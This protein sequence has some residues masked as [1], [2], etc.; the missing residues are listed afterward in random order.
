[1]KTH[2][3]R[4]TVAPG[5]PLAATS[6]SVEVL[7]EAPLTA[8]ADHAQV[9]AGDALFVWGGDGA[10]EEG[11]MGGSIE[12]N[13]VGDGALYHPQSGRWSVVAKAPLGPRK[14]AAAVWTGTEVIVAGGQTAGGQT[15]DAPLSDAASYDPET[16]TWASLPP[17]PNCPTVAARADQLVFTAGGCIAKGPRYSLFDPLT[18]TWEP[19][20]SPPSDLG[21]DEAPA[22]LLRVD[23]HIV[24]AGAT[25][26]A[27]S[28]DL[29]AR[30]WEKLTSVEASAS[31]PFPTSYAADAA[32][33]FA[34]SGE[35]DESGDTATIQALA[36]DGSW[37]HIASTPHVPSE[38][39]LYPVVADGSLL[40]GDSAGLCAMDTSAWANQSTE[41]TVHCVNQDDLDASVVRSGTSWAVARG[42]QD[43]GVLA[44]AWGGR[45]APAAGGYFQPT[46][47]GFA[48]RVNSDRETSA[49]S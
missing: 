9:M 34:F 46:A 33:V 12:G 28:F 14:M 5:R 40:Y 31:S 43:D 45:T 11:H 2:S 20:S 32:E 3:S 15:A 17:A 24:V 48:V 21:F 36:E 8:R 38:G 4:A 30:R 44:Y 27:V 41:A 10:R 1:M 22:T 26:G 39:F 42:A 23:D 29:A 47:T 49:Q 25:G 16:D 6:V 13:L 18:R 19:V 37:Q 7:P 35:T